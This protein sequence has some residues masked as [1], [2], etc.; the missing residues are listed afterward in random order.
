MA[1]IAPLGAKTLLFSV[2]PCGAGGT[3]VG[4]IRLVGAAAV[5]GADVGAG[6][7]AGTD[8]DVVAPHPIVRANNPSITLNR[9]R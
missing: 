3:S 7:A 6:A 4:V 5:A 1:G 8:V 2:K 9:R